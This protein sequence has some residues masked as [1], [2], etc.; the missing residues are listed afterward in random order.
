[1]WS[2]HRVVTWLAVGTAA[3][4]RVHSLPATSS[5]VAVDALH[6]V[7][8]SVDFIGGETVDFAAAHNI[9]T[10]SD[11]DLEGGCDS[12]TLCSTVAVAHRRRRTPVS[13]RQAVIHKYDVVSQDLC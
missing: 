10:E 13:T 6:A 2:L 4:L 5:A 8:E 11:A 3:G 7:E 9:Y 12:S 1:M